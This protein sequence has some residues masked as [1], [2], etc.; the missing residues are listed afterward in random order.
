MATVSQ[1]GDPVNGCEE[2][3]DVT[4][5]LMCQNRSPDSSVR[6]TGNTA[7]QRDKGSHCRSS[8]ETSHCFLV[9]SLSRGQNII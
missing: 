9:H 2:L 6:K 5:A 4:E 3:F 8:Q 7:N 1:V